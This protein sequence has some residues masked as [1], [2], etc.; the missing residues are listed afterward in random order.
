MALTKELSVA[1]LEI[2]QGTTR[3][4]YSFAVDG[5]SLRRFAAISRVHEDDNDNVAGYQ[6]PEVLAHIADIREYL[7]SEDP[8]L[9]TSL[10]VAFNSSV[11][12]VPSGMGE[13]A[14]DTGQCG[15]LRIPLF[16]E[17]GNPR[18]VAWIVDG[19]QRAAAIRDAAVSQ[20]PVFVT[21]F[22]A[23]SDQEQR[24][25][26]I[27]VNSP[28]P[29]AK[30]LIYELLPGTEAKLPALLR[31]RRFSAS[32]LRRL[33]KDS[34][35]PF[36]GMVRTPTNPQGVIKDN[37]ILRMIENSLSDGALYAYTAA[38]SP[39]ADREGMLTLL[40][41]YWEAT[42]TVFDEA[43]GQPPR[44]SRL[45]HGAG[46]IGMGFVMDALAEGCEPGC[47]PSAEEF[48]TRLEP[49]K[50]A[51]H[52]TEGYWDFDDGRTR[53]WNEIQNIPKDIQMLAMHL[54]RAYYECCN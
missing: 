30:D 32:L 49:L 4:L 10:V 28:K 45:M 12:F 53:N 20:F 17:L 47:E 38:E 18:K 7:E 51:C 46:I 40:K 48:R 33:N 34:N 6:R 5:K 1:A 42:A 26:F 25:Q 23:E 22:I 37:S 11:S 39:E 16:D 2:S 8:M 15:T 43:W 36:K 9:P 24:E 54:L 3:K 50:S 31:R 52:W 14:I 41:N 19:Q 21:G 35:S 44:Y 29:L 13:D 27:L